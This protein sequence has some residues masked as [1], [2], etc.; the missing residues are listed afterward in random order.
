M[1]VEHLGYAMLMKNV[2]WP[3]MAISD[4]QVAEVGGCRAGV[5][6]L[7][8]RTRATR[9]PDLVTLEWPRQG[10]VGRV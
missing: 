10:D 3:A 4:S 9:D 8:S 2:Q 5:N 1:A 7:Y 6:P